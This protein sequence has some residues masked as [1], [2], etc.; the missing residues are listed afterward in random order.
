MATATSSPSSE[1]LD[2]MVRLVTP[3]RITFQY[4]LAGP[5]R[6]AVAYLIDLAVLGLL[7]LG[8]LVGSLAL[9]LGTI[10]G[11]GLFLPAFFA[12]YF[13]YGATCEALFNGQTPGKRAVGIR[14]V[15]DQGVPIT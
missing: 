3:E 6:R 10:T 13:G 4:P 8:A 5:F 9:S 7:C 2:T 12:L 11:M 15:S 1:P 14:V